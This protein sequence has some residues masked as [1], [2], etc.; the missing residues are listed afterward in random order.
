MAKSTFLLFFMIGV[1]SKIFLSNNFLKIQVQPWFVKA[2]VFHSV[3]SAPSANGGS[4][5]LGMCCDLVDS[6]FINLGAKCL[7]F[8]TQDQHQP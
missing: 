2:S 6:K 4:T 7:E 5:R 1:G 3:N 8:L